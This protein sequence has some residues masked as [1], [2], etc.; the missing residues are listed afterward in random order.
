MTR[1]AVLKPDKKPDTLPNRRPRTRKHAAAAHDAGEPVGGMEPMLISASSPHRA[2]LS[3]KVM[4][5]TQRAT[6]FRSRLPEGL[7][8]PLAELVR[9]MNCYYSNLIE[10][11]NTHPVEIQRALFGQEEPRPRNPRPATRSYRAYRRPAL[12]R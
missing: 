7:I 6:E 8:N 3:D 11:H 12:D 4:A 1:K 10:G 2:T 9:E 5:L